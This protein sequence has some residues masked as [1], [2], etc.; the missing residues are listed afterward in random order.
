MK[1]YWNEATTFAEVMAV[2]VVDFFCF[3]MIAA[4]FI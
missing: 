1:G 3:K 2:G 4:V